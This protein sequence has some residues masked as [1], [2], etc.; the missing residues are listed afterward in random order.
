MRLGGTLIAVPLQRDEEL[1]EE[2]ATRA[3][4]ASL[5]RTFEP[6]DVVLI[7]GPLGVG[8]TTLVRGYLEALGFEGPV[9]SPTFNLLQVFETEPPVLHVDLYRVKGAQGLG[10]EDYLETHVCLVE[11]PD[12]APG[13][14]DP[15]SSW[16]IEMEFTE[17][18]RRVRVNSPETR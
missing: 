13:L 11:W 18:G 8:K 1:F 14:A 10:I 6:G 15:D 16:R 17:N 4:G 3:F 2:S 5:A 12:R 7:S 9:R